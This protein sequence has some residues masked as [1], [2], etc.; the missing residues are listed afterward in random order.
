MCRRFVASQFTD[1][2]II[3]INSR[4][5]DSADLIEFNGI[6]A[7]CFGRVCLTRDLCTVD[8]RHESIQCRPPAP[9]I[10]NNN[11]HSKNKYKSFDLHATVRP[12]AASGCEATVL[13]VLGASMRQHETEREIRNKSIGQNASAIKKWT[14]GRNKTKENRVS[15]RNVC[16]CVC[17]VSVV[18]GDYYYITHGHY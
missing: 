3:K 5:S 13:V 4:N 6:I 17:V 7:V 14:N 15:R 9:A 2:P 11:L 1:W 10:I 16:V 12:T 8:S 18:T